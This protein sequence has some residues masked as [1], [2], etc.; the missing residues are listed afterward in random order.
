MDDK[1]KKDLAELVGQ[2]IDQRF[3]DKFIP[4]FNQGFE[5]IVLPNIERLDQSLEDL[6]SRMDRIESRMDMEERKTD[7]SLDK[8]LRVENNLGDVKKELRDLRKAIV[9]LSEKNPTFEEFSR[10]DQRIKKLEALRLVA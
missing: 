9:K 5:E 8:M 7:R 4:L 3:D 6:K 2:V 1:T 10:L